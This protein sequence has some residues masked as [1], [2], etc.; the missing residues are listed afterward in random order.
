MIAAIVTLTTIF[1]GFLIGAFATS[2]AINRIE[3]RVWKKA[4]VIEELKAIREEI[5][6]ARA[7]QDRTHL[8]FAMHGVDDDANKGSVERIERIE[9]A[10]SSLAYKSFRHGDALRTIGAEIRTLEKTLAG[11]SAK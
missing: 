3:R 11:G 10:V 5:A 2:Y 9:G 7:M 1:A 8:M 6:E 4:D